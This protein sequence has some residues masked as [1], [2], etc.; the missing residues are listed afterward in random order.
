MDRFT[1]VV[2]KKRG[3]V[4]DVGGD[5]Q[6]PNSSNVNANVVEDIVMPNMEDNE[7]KEDDEEEEEGPHEVGLAVTLPP[8]LCFRDIDQKDRSVSKVKAKRL[9]EVNQNA[10]VYAN[11]NWF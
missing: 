4:D 7:D 1:F 2:P 6:I 11:V 9:N 8:C 10:V 5:P 3:R